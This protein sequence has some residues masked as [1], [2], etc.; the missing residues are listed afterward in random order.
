[1]IREEADFELL[2]DHIESVKA[3]TQDP[4]KIGALR[5]LQSDKTDMYMSFLVYMAKLGSMMTYFGLLS[6]CV[7]WI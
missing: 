1:M 2:N 5:V 6:T 3:F 4:T 7:S